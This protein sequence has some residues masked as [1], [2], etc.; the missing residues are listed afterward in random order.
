MDRIVR[1]VS[2]T[3]AVWTASFSALPAAEPVAEDTYPPE[4][5]WHTDYGWA[6]DVAKERGKM[7]LIFFYDPQNSA[8]SDRFEAETLGAPMVRR[9]LQ[10]YV[11]ARLPLQT[12]IIVDGDELTLLEHKA[13]KEMLGKPG[14]AILDFRDPQDKNYGYVVSTFP[15]TRK[16]WYGPKQMQAI[17]DLPPGTLTQRTLIYA[18]RTHPDKPASTDGQI[19][20]N[21]LKEAESQS[22]YQARIQLQGHHRWAARFP[23][24]NAL[25]PRGLTAREVCA[26]SW[27]GENLVE[28]AIECVRCWRLSSGHWSA[29]RARQGRYGYD[30]KRGRNGIWYA[31]GIFG[32]R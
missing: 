29:V 13:L 17:L 25:L 31:T 14:L 24:I 21:L 23:R 5:S 18:V 20:P 2:F 4:I 6:M 10:D 7:L 32:G 11:C 1:V 9:K 15:L 16:L 12:K 30:M 22:Q 27:P 19:D 28:A 26:E 8:Q 3:V